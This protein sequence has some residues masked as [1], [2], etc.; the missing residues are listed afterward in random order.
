VQASLD[1]STCRCAGFVSSGG[2]GNRGAKPRDNLD[3]HLE[4]SRG[5]TQCD[6]PYLDA[7]ISDSRD[8]SE[9]IC[10]KPTNA[11]ETNRPQ[12]SQKL[13]IPASPRRLKVASRLLDRRAIACNIAHVD[14][15]DAHSGLFQQQRTHPFDNDKR[16]L[17]RRFRGLRD[18]YKD[19]VAGRFNAVCGFWPDRSIRESLTMNK[20]AEL[21][22]EVIGEVQVEIGDAESGIGISV[23]D[24]AVMLSGSAPTYSDKYA[25]ERAARRV[26]GVRAVSEGVRVAVEAHEPADDAIAKAVAPCAPKGSMRAEVCPG[27]RRKGLGYVARR[28]FFDKPA[29]SRLERRAEWGRHKPALQPHHDKAGR[30]MGRRKRTLHV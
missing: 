23:D 28:S 25:A 6:V 16:S 11:S 4:L 12:L 22:K 19:C 9:C 5:E 14:A 26:P 20:N 30:I 21:Q 17:P 18:W 8:F 3:F 15:Q 24:G 2:K 13:L 29:G 27:D 7:T 1:D 10:K